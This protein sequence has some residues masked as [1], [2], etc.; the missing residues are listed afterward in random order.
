M[1]EL[2]AILPRVEKAAAADSLYGYEGKDFTYSPAYDP[3]WEAL[4]PVSRRMD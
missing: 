2:E 1:A 3:L 4:W